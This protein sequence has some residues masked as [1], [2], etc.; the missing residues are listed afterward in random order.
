MPS[1]LQAGDD[2]DVDDVVDTAAP[3]QVMEDAAKPLQQPALVEAP[4]EEEDFFAVMARQT[5]EWQ[6]SGRR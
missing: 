1:R 3:R 2:G 6:N 4:Q 5:Q